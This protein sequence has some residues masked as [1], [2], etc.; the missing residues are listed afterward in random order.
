MYDGNMPKLAIY[1]RSS[2]C[3]GCQVLRSDTEVPHMEAR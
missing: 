1:E 2:S 3:E